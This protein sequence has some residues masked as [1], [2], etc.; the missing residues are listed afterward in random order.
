MVSEANGKQTRRE[1]VGRGLLLG[2]KVVGTPFGV[3]RKLSA[4][5]EKNVADN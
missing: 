2:D 1:W 4:V 5:K 3:W